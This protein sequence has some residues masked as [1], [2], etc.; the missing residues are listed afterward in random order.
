[1]IV[2]VGQAAA[3]ARADSGKGARTPRDPS[4]TIRDAEALALGIAGQAEAAGGGAGAA[5]E[6]ALEG[7]AADAPPGRAAQQS[8]GMRTNDIVFLCCMCKHAQISENSAEMA[9]ATVR[10][11]TA[12]CA[13]LRRRR[14]RA[15]S[16]RASASPAPAPPPRNG[17]A[18]PPP[19]RSPK[20]R[21]RRRRGRSRR[22]RG[23]RRR[24]GGTGRRCGGWGGR[25]ICC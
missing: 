17:R 14:G 18:R 19:S 12:V 5:G 6:R 2:V 16:S 22:R 10:R 7:A 9:L 11:L 8:A 25:W 3:A 4:R 20:C 1:M 21:A 13:V 24:R 23:R 15:T